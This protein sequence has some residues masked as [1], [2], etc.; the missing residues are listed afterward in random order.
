MLISAW[1]L[2][3]LG[4]AIQTSAVLAGIHHWSAWVVLVI[5]AFGGWMY[6][7]PP[8]A[9]SWRGWGE[10]TNALLGGTLLPLYG[11]VTLSGRVEW[12]F[13]LVCLPFTLLAFANLLAVT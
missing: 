12:T 10:L 8:L 6:S 9:L 11:Y 5:G 1:I 7:L 4:I 13:L 2:L 3:A